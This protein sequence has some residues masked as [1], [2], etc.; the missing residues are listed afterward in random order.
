MPGIILVSVLEFMGLP[1]ALASSSICIKV[2]MGK[3]EYQIWDKGDFSFPLTSLRDNLI[4]TLQD[5]DGI[6]ISHAGVE[7]KSIVEKGLWDDLFPLEGGGH[8]HMKLQFVLSE[9]ERSRIRMMN[10]ADRYE[11]ISSTIS[12]PQGVDVHL[13]HKELVEKNES[14]SLPADFPTEAISSN[15]TSLLL[16][17][18]RLDVAASNNSIPHNLGE[19]SGHNI[20][21][22]SQLGKSPRNVK[23]MISAFESGLAQDMRSPIKS[24]PTRSQTSKSRIELKSQHLNEGKTQITKTEQSISG[25]VI[26]L[27]LAEELQHT[28]TDI[29][30]RGEQINLLGASDRSKLSQDTGQLEELNTK[31]FQIL[32]TKSSLK[33]KFHVVHK[34]VSREE[35]K[36]HQDLMRI[37][38]SETATV[39]WRILDEYSGGHPLSLFTGKQDSCGNPVIEESRREIQ[40]T[41]LQE[42]NIQGASTHKLESVHYCEDNH[43]LFKN[44]G[45]WIFP[46][47]ARQL[48]VTTGGKKV[49]DL[50]GGCSTKPKV[51]QGNVNLSMQENMEKH[52]V[53]ARTVIKADKD[54]KECQKIGKSKP[55][56]SEDIETSG[57]PVGQ[58]IKVAIMLGFGILVLLT[59]KRNYR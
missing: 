25:R 30:K 10:D 57:G 59:R 36:S 49:M 52:S 28:P 45:A 50:M 1:H 34:E 43:Y 40:F 47:E 53:D 35:E 14:K 6:K 32:G 41:N 16:G 9:E 24:P 15:E 21:K 11:E 22:Q 4:V 5:A 31:K 26:N 38:T 51:H 33:N 54:K 37:S 2:S 19:D 48:C 27:F 58:A 29:R 42:F 44:S 7:I 46:D 12:A 18:S 13:S 55:E 17:G 20:Q 56:N 39:S 8:I 3:I 23:N